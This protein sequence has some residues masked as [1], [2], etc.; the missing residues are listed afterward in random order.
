MNKDTGYVT[1]GK[2]TKNQGNKG[3]VKVIPYTDYPERF[4]LIDRVFLVREGNFIKKDIENVRYH[5]NFVVIKFAGIDN[6]AD[7]LDLR[8]Y[9]IKIP[10]EEILPLEDDEYY[11]DHLIGFKVYTTE[12]VFLGD[13]IEVLTTGGTDVFKV[14]GEKKEYLIPA[15]KEIILEINEETNK[16]IVDPIPGL[17]DL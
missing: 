1:I 7:A 6:I 5:K 2:I 12:N 17:L 13:L 10:E 8:E 11:I 9:D 3:E 4:Q 16:I 15:A 14:K